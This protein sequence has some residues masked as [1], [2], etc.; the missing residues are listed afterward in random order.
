MKKL[1]VSEF[2]K[3]CTRI[4]RE[5]P[6]DREPIL[7]TSRAKPLARITPAVE[8]GRHPA[9]GALAGAV[10][11]IASDFDEPIGDQDWEAAQ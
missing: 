10:R 4:L 8:P 7:I 2:K 3:H 6:R 1:P 11:E 5:L 9:W